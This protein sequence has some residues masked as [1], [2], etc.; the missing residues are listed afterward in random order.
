MRSSAEFLWRLNR[1]YVN[2]LAKAR[3]YL[4]L[5]ENMVVQRGAGEMQAQLL[6]TLQ[7]ARTRLNQLSEAHR[8]WCYTYFYESPETKRMVQSSQ[9]VDRALSSFDH[10]RAQQSNSFDDLAERLYALPR[11]ASTITRI[12]SGDLWE[13]TQLALSE[14]VALGTSIRH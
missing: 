9:A 5:L 11:P 1:E 7:V 2:R 6:P 12:P 13:M 8:G 14:L 3:T 10:M 4:D